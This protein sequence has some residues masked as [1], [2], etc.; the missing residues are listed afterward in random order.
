M[1]PTGATTRST[2]SPSRRKRRRMRSP[3]GPRWS[4]RA[5]VWSSLSSDGASVPKRRSVLSGH[6]HGGGLPMN[7]L[8]AINQAKDVITV[9][10]VYGDPYQE[11]GITVIPAATVMGGG[12]GGG[13]TAGNGGAGFGVRAR[14]AGA[15]G[16]K[17]GEG[18]GR[19]P[20]ELHWAIPV[21]PR[22]ALLALLGARSGVPPPAKAQP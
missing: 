6:D 8:D 10:R 2:G 22:L 3:P 1:T 18:Q 20:I 5:R 17:S 4:S 12:G 14:P 21:G 7:A 16:I 15:W 19:P 11:D 9:R 13:D